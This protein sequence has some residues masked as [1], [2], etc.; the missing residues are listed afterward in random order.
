MSFGNPENS[1]MYNLDRRNRADNIEDTAKLLLPLHAACARQ[2]EKAAI[3]PH[4][5]EDLYSRKSILD[6]EEYV[7][8]RK[9]EF[10][11]GSHEKMSSH[12]ELTKG[13]VKKLSEILEYQI[14]KGIN[15]DGWIP[16]V[17]VMKTAEAEPNDASR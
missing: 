6:D 5:F 4:D 9:R 16:Y 7:E 12:G 8:K 13:E 3:K 11:A 17:T 1:A 10:E 14:I 2:L 15:V